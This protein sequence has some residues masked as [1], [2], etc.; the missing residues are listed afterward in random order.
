MC[1]AWIFVSNL[2][3]PISSAQH[4]NSISQFTI[5][6]IAVAQCLVVLTEDN[7]VAWQILNDYAQELL[8]LLSIREEGHAYTL[9]RTLSAAICANIP[10]FLASHS[11]IIFVTLSKTLENNHRTT[12]ANVSSVIPLNV[13]RNELFVTE[14]SNAMEEET[15]AQ[16]SLRRRKQDMPT[17]VELEVQSVGYL[18][19]AQRIGAETITNICTIEDEGW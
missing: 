7:P 12:L 11:N 14:D 19:E 18:L 13:N 3:V 1:S 5:T 10:A 16:A 6:A 2:V 9:L 15:D 4:L 8:S 17:E